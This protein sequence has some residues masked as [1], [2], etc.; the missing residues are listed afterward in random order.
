MLRSKSVDLAI[1]ALAAVLSACG[2]PGP[3]ATPGTS[4]ASTAAATAPASSSP[5]PVSPSALSPSAL[6]PSAQAA[7]YAQI[8]QQV[9]SIRELKRTRPV[10]P[11]ILDAA[12]LRDELAKSAA[13]DNPPAVVARQER[14]MKA[15]GVLTSEANLMALLTA[16]STSQVAGFY[17]PED[18]RLYVVSRSGALG[19]VERTTF[20]HEFTHALQD[21]HFG[22]LKEIGAD[23]VGHG[24]RDLARLALIEGDATL[25]MTYWAEQNLSP[26]ELLDLLRSSLDPGQL[27]ALND[28]PPYLRDTALFPY[29]A[30]LQFVM[31]LQAP[32]GW[33]GVN[34][35]F[36]KPPVSTEQVLHPEKYRASEEPIPVSLPADL[37]TR[38]GEG[39]TLDSEDTLGEEQLQAWLTAVSLPAGQAATAS[40]GWGGDRVGLLTGPNDAW[41]LA[42][43]TVW[44]TDQDA[45][46][47]VGAATAALDHVGHPGRVVRGTAPREAWVLIASDA[48]NAGALAAITGAD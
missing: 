11:T 2:S 47:F 35:G 27:A 18:G 29:Q 41:A 12:G 21:Q 9:E 20:A 40:A 1:L 4:P 19:G 8:E 26:A 6:S 15:L 16:F 17:R 25:T 34:A 32:G 33:A 10:D 31:A 44:D 36:E 39:W 37:A 43:R 5:S 30:G 24:D 45:A 7:I 23:E 42:L 48:S 46:E 28:T 3:T 14:V 38:M 22:L 13:Q